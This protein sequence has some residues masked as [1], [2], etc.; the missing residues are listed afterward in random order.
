MHAKYAEGG[1][2]KSGDNIRGLVN[3]M[4]K[5]FSLDTPKDMTTG[6]T[7]ADIAAGF[8]PG[9]GTAQAA[10]DFERAR[11]EDDRLG[12]A[13]AGVGMV[14]VVG[15]V[16]KPLKAA[17]KSAG[18]APDV[19]EQKMLMGVYRGYAGDNPS[20][21]VHYHG[22]TYT[23]GEPV[24]RPLYLTRDPEMAESYVWAKGGELVKVDPRPRKTAS[25]KTLNELAAEYVPE[26]AKYQYTPASALDANLHGDRPVNRLQYELGRNPNFYDSARAFD[27]GFGGPGKTP[28]GEV[29]VMLPGSRV[30]PVPDVELFV[31]PQKRIADYYAQKRAA[32]TGGVPHAEM[33]LIDPFAGKQYGHSTL[34]TGKQ[35]PMITKARKL[36][37]EDVKERTQLYAEGGYVEYDPA[38][39]DDIVNKIREGI[40]G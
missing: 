22:G 15:G 10:R 21:L 25:Q 2:V 30:N 14:P 13:L 9:L 16:V 11:R 39:V 31:S 29:L 4:R 28:E 7:V 24:T 8:V 34:G 6:E 18:K 32:Q 23:P 37:P 40:Y 35:P 20:P 17:A 19:K 27:I 12:M 38:A 5:M 1:E 33:L 26:N 36:K 3:S